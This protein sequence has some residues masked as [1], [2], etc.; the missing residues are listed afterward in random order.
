MAF[1]PCLS[2]VL[3]VQDGDEGEAMSPHAQNH[4]GECYCGESVCFMNLEDQAT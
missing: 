4:P 3:F 1:C 2:L